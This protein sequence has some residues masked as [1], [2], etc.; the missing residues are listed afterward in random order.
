MNLWSS[1]N[2]FSTSSNA[3]GWR[4]DAR[5]LRPENDAARGS[6]RAQA[7]APTAREID[8]QLAVV[9]GIWG[10]LSALLRPVANGK[11]LE[12]DTIV[13]VAE[14]NLRLLFEMNKAVEMYEA[15]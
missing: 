13:Q 11:A 2:R 3:R 5:S 15:L 7:R 4:Q 6:G 9:Q 1:L 12:A 14:A 8:V 10:R